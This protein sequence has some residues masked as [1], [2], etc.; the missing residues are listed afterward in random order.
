MS[1]RVAN[2]KLA[3]KS[4]NSATERNYI[5]GSKTNACH[6]QFVHEKECFTEQIMALSRSE[7]I[8]RRVMDNFV[9]TNSIFE[10]YLNPV[11]FTSIIETPFVSITNFKNGQLWIAFQCGSQL[12]LDSKHKSGGVRGKKLRLK[13]KSISCE[14][15]LVLLLNCLLITPRVL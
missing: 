3:K 15:L 1:E 2:K 5:L 13:S 7:P 14:R 6:A 12:A 9:Q 4:M 8:P 11:C 10:R